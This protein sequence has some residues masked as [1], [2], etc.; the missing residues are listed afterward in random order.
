M[1]PLSCHPGWLT[2]P[3]TVQSMEME[4]R[5]PGVGTSFP[6]WACS[7]S[8]IYSLHSPISHNSAVW[9]HSHTQFQKRLGIK[10]CILGAQMLQQ[11]CITVEERENHYLGTLS[12]LL[13]LRLY[14]SAI[15]RRCPGLVLSQPSPSSCLLSA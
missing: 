13:P 8:C 4:K 6:F 14:V 9:S 2:A 3:P 5:G 11:K 7:G 12:A 10:V 15:T 1:L